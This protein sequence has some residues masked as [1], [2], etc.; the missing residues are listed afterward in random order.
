LLAFYLHFGF[1]PYQQPFP[2]L[3][4]ARLSTSIKAIKTIKSYQKAIKKLLSLGLK[5]LARAISKLFGI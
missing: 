3:L 1:L 4:L 5:S 2:F